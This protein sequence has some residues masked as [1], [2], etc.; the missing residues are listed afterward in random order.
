MPGVL[1]SYRTVKW[2]DMSIGFIKG[3]DMPV[4]SFVHYDATALLVERKYKGYLEMANQVH[5]TS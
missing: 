2:L 3:I 5:F 4:Y 1:D